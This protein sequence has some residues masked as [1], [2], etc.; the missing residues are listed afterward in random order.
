MADRTLAILIPVLN[1]PALVDRVVGSALE[2]TP[3]ARVVLIMTEGYEAE[4]QA[5]IESLGKFGRDGSVVLMT[6]E[7]QTVGDYAQKINAGI[8]A[9]TEPYLFFGADDIVFQPGWF[10]AA[11]N[12]MSIDEGTGVGVV[13][14]DDMGSW[15]PN[16]PSRNAIR[17]GEHSTHCLVARW[18]CDL[19]SID[20]PDEVLTTLYAHEFVDDEFC[21][22]AR[23]RGSWAIAPDSRVD[24]RHPNLGKAES[25]ESY[26]R[27]VD[28][29]PPGRALY[30]SRAHLWGEDPPRR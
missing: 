6:M 2:T 30:R 7:P 19:G 13:G 9:T 10:G 12:M 20:N 4:G 17:D 11:L 18:Y 3:D 29:I 8:K 5:C 14:T 25:D 26:A 22:T 21:A 28:R 16:S 23:Y 15:R 27:S 24:H 1:R